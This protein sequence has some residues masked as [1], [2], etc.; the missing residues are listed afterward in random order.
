MRFDSI[1]QQIYEG[2]QK[3]ERW[4]WQYPVFGDFVIHVAM[5]RDLKL[6]KRVQKRY[7]NWGSNR[8]MYCCASEVN[9]QDFHGSPAPSFSALGGGATPG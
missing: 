2:I 8:T 9:S 3:D 1:F 6:E 7:V 4:P 5:P